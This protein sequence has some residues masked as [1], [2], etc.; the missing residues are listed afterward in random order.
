VLG[1]FCVAAAWMLCGLAAARYP[2]PT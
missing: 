1:G 2:R